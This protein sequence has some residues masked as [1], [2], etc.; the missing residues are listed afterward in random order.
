MS[1]TLAQ[2]FISCPLPRLEARLLLQHITGL[3]HAQLITHNQTMLSENQFSELQKLVKRR[4]AGEPIAY[5]LGEREF[6][7]RTFSV[8]PATLIPRPE[9]E[10]LLEAALLRLPEN[11]ILWDLGTGSGIIAISCQ[12]ERTD[13]HVFASDVSFEALAIAQYNA[14]H[15]HA[16][17]SFAQGTWFEANCV[18]RLPENTVHIIVSNPP[19]IECDDMHLRQGD[20]R[21]E[22]S[23][24]LT[25]FADGLTHIRTIAQHAPRYLAPAGFLLLEH[26]YNQ[27][28]A[29]RGIL[30]KN[31]FVNI[32]TLLDLAGH[33]RI[34]LGQKRFQSGRKS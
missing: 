11:G 12:L 8:S 4:K 9:T 22:P 18:F 17:V 20:L 33:E 19:Y 13:A 2:W 27:G 21:F 31:Q 23:I 7:G 6:Y 28:S 10:H 29:V 5:I 15:W 16:P 24:A 34:T 25:D 14:Q 32:Q 30:S 3:T 1:S 26:G